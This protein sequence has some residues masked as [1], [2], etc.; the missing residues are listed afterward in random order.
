M[1][2]ESNS[3]ENSEYT[4]TFDENI[5]LFTRTHNASG[6]KWAWY[7]RERPKRTTPVA[8]NGMTIAKL[9][10]AGNSVRVKHLRWALYLPHYRTWARSSGHPEA[11][12]IVVPSSLR[13][14]PMYVFLPKGGYTH[15]IIKNPE[16]KYICLS[17]ECSDKDSF[18]YA[19][20]VAAALDR[21]TPLEMSL[22]GV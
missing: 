17:S 2:T 15:I 1:T 12:K 18:C 22:L 13:Q 14:D 3:T 6:V 20:G 8:R 21:M 11:K 4:T 10:Q 9:Q 16:G 5:K 7:A 19:S